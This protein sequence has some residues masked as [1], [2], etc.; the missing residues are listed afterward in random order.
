MTAIAFVVYDGVTLLDLAGA[1]DPITRLRTMGF[2]DD[3]EY[4][5]CGRAQTARTS[6]GLVIIPDSIRRDLAKFD[7]VIIPGGNGVMDLMKDPAFLSWIRVASDK[8]TVAA[9]CGGSL[10]IGV[11]GML[12]DRKATTHPAL[13]GVL[14]QY[15]R[16]VS[17]DRIVEDGNIITAGGV[18][19]AIDLGLYL[20]EK[21]AGRDVREKIRVQMDYHAYPYP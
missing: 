13:Q 1:Y 15:A 8:T 2:I 17:S 11:A 12:H 18:T 7:Y 19:S 16:E 20:C 10:L 9:F 5:V 21:I 3:L 14:R 4:E 6:E